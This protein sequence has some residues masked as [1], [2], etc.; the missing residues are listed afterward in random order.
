MKAKLHPRIGFHTAGSGGNPTGIGEKYVKRLHEAGIPVAITCADGDVGIGDALAN[1]HPGDV[2]IFRV[3]R[4]G[5]ERFA[6]PDYKVTPEEAAAKYGELIDPFIHPEVTKHKDKIWLAYGNELDQG[7]ARWVFKWSL[8][9]VKLLNGKGYKGVGPNWATGNPGDLGAWST[10]ESLDFLRYCAEN[11][12]TAAVG[13]HEYSLNDDDL[14]A[15]DGTLVGRYRHIVKVCRENHIARPTIL[16]KEFGYGAFS[17]PPA[18]QI[19]DDLRRLYQV[20][21][22]YPPATFW[23]L[24]PGFDGIANQL[25]PAIGDIADFIA[26]LEVDVDLAE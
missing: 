1:P 12:E 14:L 3:V 6:V 9:M 16:I 13:I 21:P 4:D 15:G 22:D 25:Q 10:P 7:N 23:Y 26:S 17:V 24:G 8:E 19:V 2:L 20:Y 5:S 11:P 18:S